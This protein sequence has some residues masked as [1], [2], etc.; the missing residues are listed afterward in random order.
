MI[1]WQQK[2]PQAISMAL[3]VAQVHAVF[4]GHFHMAPLGLVEKLGSRALH[5]ICH[6]S[7]Q[8]LL[9]KSTNSW[10]DS[11]INV[12]KYF[13]AADAANFVSI[14]FSFAFYS[15]TICYTFKQPMCNLHGGLSLYPPF[16]LLS[17]LWRLG[18]LFLHASLL[19][20]RVSFNHI[21]SSHTAQ[22]C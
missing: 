2:S 1:S 3:S 4:G 16:T 17:M 18:V 20:P 11:S 7:K 22:G 10:I 19:S 14:S 5:L 15:H 9:S 8:D 13:S 21:S 6:L 12:T